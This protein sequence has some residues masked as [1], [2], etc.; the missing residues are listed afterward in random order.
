MSQ[1]V[2][3]S[4]SSYQ[5]RDAF[6]PYRDSQVPMPMLDRFNV[7]HPFQMAIDKTDKRKENSRVYR[8]RVQGG[9]IGA[10]F[11][12]KF[13]LKP[14]DRV[15]IF[16]NAAGEL[17]IDCDTPTSQ[18]HLMKSA[19]SPHKAS[20]MASGVKEAGRPVAVVS[21]DDNPGHR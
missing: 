1:Q 21:R 14:G 5:K 10:R 20:E 13:A 8:L 11:L 9:M 12:Q 17:I 15:G 18:S 7:V 19:L 6:L 16:A 2:L 3:E 4:V